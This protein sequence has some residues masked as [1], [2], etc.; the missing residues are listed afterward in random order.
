MNALVAVRANA[1]GLYSA[2]RMQRDNVQLKLAARSLGISPETLANMKSG[3]LTK[4]AAITKSASTKSVSDD[5]VTRNVNQELDRDAFLQL[6]V[7]QMQ[8]Q[9]PLDPVDNSEML[10]QLA[11]FSS[12]E[13]MER[14]NDGFESFVGGIDQLN[15]M[16]ASALLGKNVSG[17]DMNGA[18]VEG[19]VDRVHLDGSI[20]YLTIGESLMSMAGVIGIDEPVGK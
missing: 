11:Q 16:T 4:S 2:S 3:P 10:A 18:V 13:Q 6:L 17:I 19:E 7:K 1:T 5:T 20:V 15:F 9:D 14:L 12:L 8:N